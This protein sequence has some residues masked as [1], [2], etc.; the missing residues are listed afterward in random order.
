LLN[1][2]I[3]VLVGM[4]SVLNNEMGWV[5]EKENDSELAIWPGCSRVTVRPRIVGARLC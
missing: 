5:R 1:G 4:G 3:A 2:H